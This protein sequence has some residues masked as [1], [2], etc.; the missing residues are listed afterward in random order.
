MGAAVINDHRP[1]VEAGGVK[2]TQLTPFLGVGQVGSAIVGRRLHSPGSESQAITPL[3]GC[4]Y[5]QISFVENFIEVVT[6]VEINRSCCKPGTRFVKISL[7]FFQ[8]LGG[9]G[10]SDNLEVLFLEQ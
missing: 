6:L 10:A 2:L 9:S 7:Q 5:D 1:M 4:P 8:M 3:A